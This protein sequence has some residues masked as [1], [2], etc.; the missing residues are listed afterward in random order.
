M[1]NTLLILISLSVAKLA[2]AASYQVP[3]PHE[4]L[5]YSQWDLA[6]KAEA[7]I[8]GKKLSVRYKLPGDL[9]GNDHP[10]FAFSGNINSSFVGVAGNGV[11]GYCMLAE[12]KPLTC[13]LKY[14]EMAIDA[15]ARD[16]ALAENH[17]G[18]ALIQRTKVARL[19]GADP[20]GILSVSI[21]PSDLEN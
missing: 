20:A 5:P 12:N 18:E 16:K 19:F 15:A 9:V 6:Q 2:G 3:V 11:S 10:G 7:S 13:M 8:D 1:K 21:L 17:T 4:L 14:P